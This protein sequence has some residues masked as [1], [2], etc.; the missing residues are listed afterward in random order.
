MNPCLAL[1][2]SSSILSVAV[3]SD[4]K[5]IRDLHVPGLFRHAENLLPVLVRLLR[6]KKVRLDALGAI[7]I[8]RGPGSFT[9]LRIGFSTLKGLLAVKKIPC[10]GALSLDVIAAGIRLP[11]PSCLAICL[12][13]YRGQFYVRHYHN[14][15]GGW[16]PLGKARI[17]TPESF[18]R[19]LPETAAIAGD[20][21]ERYRDNL[22]KMA[23]AA[24]KKVR[25]LRKDSWYPKA[26][27]LVRWHFEKSPF[28]KK[29]AKPKELLPL[30]FRR[31]EAEE[32]RKRHDDRR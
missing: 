1:D 13:A 11:R 22:Q 12:D 24:G 27:V 21:L 16:R 26:S 2:T 31:S 18:I 15:R 28:L 25:F 29:L 6:K 10:Y 20:A 30:Y 14:A 7:L 23:E 5:K 8:N 3:S 19:A 32:R 9:G 17:E 4:G